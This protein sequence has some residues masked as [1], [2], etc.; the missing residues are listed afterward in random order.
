LLKLPGEAM[1]MN[2]QWLSV[3]MVCAVH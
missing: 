3:G 1:A 2:P